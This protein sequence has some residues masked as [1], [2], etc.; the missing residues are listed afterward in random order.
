MLYASTVSSLKLDL[1]GHLFIED[2]FGTVPSDINSSGYKDFIRHKS[3]AIPLTEAEEI[4][5]EEVWLA[6]P[7]LIHSSTFV[8]DPPPFSLTPSANKECS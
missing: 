2:I 3:A 1:G 7:P 4:R 6:P 5:K 8:D